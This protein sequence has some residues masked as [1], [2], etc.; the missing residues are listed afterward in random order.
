MIHSP[1][2]ESATLSMLCDCWQ[3][4]AKRKRPSPGTN[5]L[6]E[7]LHERIEHDMLPMLVHLLH[8]RRDCDIN[9]LLCT[10]R[11]ITVEHMFYENAVTQSQ[12]QQNIDAQVKLITAVVQAARERL[13]A[14][15]EWSQEQNPPMMFG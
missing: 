15:G 4:A 12:W 11:R 1:E 2:A 6:L 14:E 10:V 3:Q 8:E 9:H 5:P 7:D 13:I